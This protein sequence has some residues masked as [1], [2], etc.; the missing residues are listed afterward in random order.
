MEFS[1]TSFFEH[2]LPDSWF[3]SLSHSQGF[4]MTH[5]EVTQSVHDA[6]DFF[7]IDDPMVV[8]EGWTTGVYP[9]LSITEMDDVLIYNRD[10]MQDM[11]ITEK[12]AFDLI[13]THEGTHRMLQGM[14]TGFSP[15]Q[16]ELCCDFMA[17]VRAGLNGLDVTQME[18]SLENTHASAS[19][20]DGH[21]RVNS[22]EKGV[23]F[24]EQYMNEH[25][26]PPTFT[27]CIENFSET[28]LDDHV[29]AWITL[30]EEGAPIPSMNSDSGNSEMKAYS[31][32][33]INANKNR[34]EHEMR[35][36][37][38]YMRHHQSIAA[39]KERMGQSH[40]DSD[41]QYNVAK[42][43]FNEAKR[44]YQKWDNMKPEVK[45]FY[46][47]EFSGQKHQFEVLDDNE[48][49]PSKDNDYGEF[50][51]F[52]DDRAYHLRAAQDAKESAEWHHKRADEAIARGDLSAARDHNS[53]AELYEKSRRDHL[54]S[55][56]KCTK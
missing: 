26:V 45:G 56:K 20:P 15:H 41:H 6:S 32:S 24:A 9:N 11:G 4:D 18:N 38:S 53:K 17:G 14:N 36:Q 50:H 39:S 35:V 27:E 49:Y 46:Q 48:I 10:Q 30:R 33:E 40:E 16:E 23:E 19:H 55:A 43:K 51:G 28:V 21:S 3:E 22:I 52:V 42:E 5:E 7:H 44:E 29:L 47:T 13:M 37:E 8:K 12:H 54:D 25:G 1:F 34:A 31:Q 2:I